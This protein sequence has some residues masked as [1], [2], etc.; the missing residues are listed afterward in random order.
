M[1]EHGKSSLAG[2]QEDFSQALWMSKDS[3][4][5]EE[6]FGASHLQGEV[7]GLKS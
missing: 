6:N 3:V 4:N 2:E 1:K 7:G 5:S